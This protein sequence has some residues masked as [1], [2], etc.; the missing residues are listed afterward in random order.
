MAQLR[1]NFI[2]VGNGVT[3]TAAN[4]GGSSGDAFDSVVAPPSGGLLQA[5]TTR[6]MHAELSC[7]LQTGATTGL[8]SFTWSTSMGIKSQIWGRFYFFADTGSLP[9]A[10]TRIVNFMSGATQCASIVLGI[11][12]LLSIRNAAGTDVTTGAV[13]VPTNAWCRIE[14]RYLFSTTV[15]SAAINLYNTPDSTTVTEGISA[16]ASQA[17]GAAS[18]NTYLFGMPATSAT[19][20]PWSFAD[21]ALDDTAFPGPTLIAP[22]VMLGPMR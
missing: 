2:G 18:A 6:Q 4:S 20:G 13:P 8:P 12:G 21:V 14:F 7:Q 3:L 1:N 5:N 22:N 19:R 10:K 17:F 15:G 9:A 16:A 11:T